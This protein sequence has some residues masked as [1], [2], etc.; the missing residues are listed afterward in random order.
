MGLL[1]GFFKRKKLNL[2]EVIT[3]KFENEEK[4]KVLLDSP[5]LDNRQLIL[6]HD[7]IFSFVIAEIY[8]EINFNPI[9]QKIHLKK[10][11]ADIIEKEK[12]NR[13]FH[14]LYNSFVDYYNGNPNLDKALWNISYAYLETVWGIKEKIRD[15]ILLTAYGTYLSRV[16]VVIR[17][18]FIESLSKLN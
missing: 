10:D 9:F 6:N 11:Y 7:N 4:K 1:N 17:D 13:V 8:F 5:L 15:P 2:F 3:Y 16:R 14:L 18:K 12:N